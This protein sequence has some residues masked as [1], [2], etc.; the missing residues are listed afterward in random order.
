MQEFEGPSINRSQIKEMVNIAL[1]FH[2]LA[3]EE[4]IVTQ[5]LETGQKLI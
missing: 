4:Q 1:S 2:Y 3:N 5:L